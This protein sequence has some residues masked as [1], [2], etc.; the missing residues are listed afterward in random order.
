MDGT[1]DRICKPSGAVAGFRNVQNAFWSGYKHHHILNWLGFSWP[2]GF[3]CIGDNI[4]GDDS[5]PRKVL[6][7][8]SG[9]EQMYKVIP[10]NIVHFDDAY[11][12]STI[13]ECWIR[14]LFNSVNC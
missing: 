12:R 6:S 13:D 9:K 2:D 4:M 5:T 1:A 7:L 8:A 11:Q 14:L 10:K 3:I